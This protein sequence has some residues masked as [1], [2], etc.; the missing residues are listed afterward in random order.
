VDTD[1]D[2]DTDTD[3][4]SDA[5]TDTDSECTGEACL[6]PTDESSKRSC[7]CRN[8]GNIDSSSPLRSLWRLCFGTTE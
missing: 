6:A 3:S 8:I 4:D 2:S 1:S 7:N 5:D